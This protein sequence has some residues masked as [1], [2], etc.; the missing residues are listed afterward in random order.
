MPAPGGLAHATRADSISTATGKAIEA[1]LRIA[2]NGIA[3]GT[4]I[5]T[6]GANTRIIT[7]T[8]TE[9]KIQFAAHRPR[10]IELVA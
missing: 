8:I 2:T 6:G 10:H 3:T 7:T 9:V 4:A 1:A 5:V